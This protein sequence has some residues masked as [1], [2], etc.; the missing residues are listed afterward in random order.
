MGAQRCDLQH[1]GRNAAICSTL[2]RMPS[3]GPPTIA[4]A[5]VPMATG[6]DGQTGHLL[7]VRRFIKFYFNLQNWGRMI[8]RIDQLTRAAACAPVS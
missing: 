7:L 1:Y 6:P 5:A 8:G 3:I 4:P 2:Q